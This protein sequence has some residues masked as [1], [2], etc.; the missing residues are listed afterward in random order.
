MS[1]ASATP[2]PIRAEAV[3]IALIVVLALS[4]VGYVLSQRQQELRASPVGLDGLQLWLSAA[5][6]SAQSFSGGWTLDPA[7]V[8]LLVLPLHDT[9][10]DADMTPARS[11][12]ELLFQQDE[13]DQSWDVLR[14][15]LRA[16]NTLV[17]LP[18]WRSG[19]RLTGIAHPALLVEAARVD[20]ILTELTGVPSVRLIRSRQ[21]FTALPYRDATG[22]E[23]VTEIYAAQLFDG[24]GC[25]PIIGSGPKTLLASCPLPGWGAG[26]RVLILSDPD[27]LNNHGLRLGQNATIA[28][29]FLT[30]EAG[31]GTVLIDYSR[32]SWFAKPDA[33]VQRD[34]SWA[35]LLQFFEPPFLALW[36]GAGLTL[37]LVL[38]RSLRRAGPV[39][40]TAR[41]ADGKMQA[42]RARARLMRLTGQ[43]GAMIGDYA[44]ARIA[45][46]AARLVGPGH[47]R[48]IGEERAFLRFVARRRADL[49]DRLE[50]SLARLH[51]LPRRIPAATAIHHVDELEQIL[52]LIA[53][54]P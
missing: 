25:D 8:G 2:S 48:Q 39:L 43:D 29:D 33:P 30:A 7:S 24:T 36:L 3:I 16:A 27:L 54:D 32:E 42:I 31:S 21:V 20:R 10:L 46:T 34:R 5:G 49:A 18:K 9:A 14:A 26:G 40:A 13:V 12:E 41:T 44:T 35:D 15:K 28:R 45:A 53:N 52:E 4:A 38:W 19:M 51:A 23:M 37:A 47:A 50:T 17:V 1:E 6:G 11:K 22:A